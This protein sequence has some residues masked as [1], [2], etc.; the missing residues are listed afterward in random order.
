MQRRGANHRKGEYL[1]L[2]KCKPEQGASVGCG[3]FERVA[4]AWADLA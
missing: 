4:Q 3:R 1:P 2:W